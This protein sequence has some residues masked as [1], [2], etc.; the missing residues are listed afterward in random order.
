MAKMFGPR[1]RVRD[2]NRLAVG[3]GKGIRKRLPNGGYLIID[4]QPAMLAVLDGLVAAGMQIIDSADV[5]DQPALG[6][7]LVQRGGVAGWAYGKRVA[8]MGDAADDVQ[9]PRGFRTSSNGVDVIAGF[10]FPARFNERGTVHQPARPF[11]APAFLATA[12]D[13]PGIL[14]EHFG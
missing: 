8:T 10:T 14:A 7:G 4:T 2:R 5:P 3:A 1:L 11:L 13:V 9:K 12:G 6:A